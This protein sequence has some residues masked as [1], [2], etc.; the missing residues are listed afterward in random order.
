MGAGEEE[1][2]QVEVAPSVRMVVE[3][4]DLVKAILSSGLSV[5]DLC[6]AACVC[7]TW[8]HVV[9][10]PA[11]WARVVLSDRSISPEQVGR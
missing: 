8:R 2:D 11:F 4:G 1:A 6:R 3:N 10:D 5:V 7:G 9:D